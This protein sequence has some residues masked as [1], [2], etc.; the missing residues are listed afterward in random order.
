[1]S[2][3]PNEV[4][5]E[6]LVRQGPYDSKIAYLISVNNKIKSLIAKSEEDKQILSSDIETIRSQMV[7]NK[8]FNTR[9]DFYEWL[10]HEENILTLKV[11]QCF[12]IIESDVPDY[13]WT[14]VEMRELE[15]NKVDF[16]PI[17]DKIESEKTALQ[18]QIDSLRT[19]T[20]TTFKQTLMRCTYPVGSIMLRYDTTT[21][22]SL[23]GLEGTSWIQLSSGYYLLTGTTSTVGQSSSSTTTGSTTLTIDHIPSHKHDVPVGISWGNNIMNHNESG[24]WGS[25]L[26]Q[27]TWSGAGYGGAYSYSFACTNT[28]ASSPLSHNHTISPSYIRVV[29]YRRTV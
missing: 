19:L 11:G 10:T 14:G 17:Y 15:T 7:I 13:W 24:V 27:G 16:Q 6:P 22:T 29:A 1:M 8:V 26:A 5:F 25:P 20:D 21:P 28:G 3:T 18:Q 9:N 2:D 12:Y 23:E 4:S